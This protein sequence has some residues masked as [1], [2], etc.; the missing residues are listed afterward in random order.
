MGTMA[1]CRFSYNSQAGCLAAVE[2]VVVVAGTSISSNSRSHRGY[3][4]LAEC[5]AAVGVTA[6]VV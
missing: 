6:A 3:S 2:A 4:S 5:S 1:T